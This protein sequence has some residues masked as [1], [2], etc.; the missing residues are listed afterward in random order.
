MVF[1]FVELPKANPI[2]STTVDETV[3]IGQ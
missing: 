1:P 3:H 2:D